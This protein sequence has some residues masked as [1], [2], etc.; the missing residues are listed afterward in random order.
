MSALLP[1]T[2]QCSAVV[3]SASATLTSTRFCSSARTAWTLPARAASRRFGVC[4]PATLLATHNIATTTARE[5]LREERIDRSVA[6]AK[7]V[8]LAA[9]LVRNRQ[10]QVPDRRP[11]RELHVAMPLA[12]AAANADHRQR[13]AGMRVRVA[14]AAAVHD[15]RVIEHR[16]VAIGSGLQLLDELGE[17]R[18][19]IG[20]HLHV[21]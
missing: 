10:P 18:R 6:V 8:D 12:N 1:R 16:S 4:P 20:I 14:H 13:I 9:V 7:S 17:E 2:A 5:R 19:V 3:P 11:R 15:Q 21:L